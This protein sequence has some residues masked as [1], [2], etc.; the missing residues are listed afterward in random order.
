MNELNHIDIS[1]WDKVG[2]GGNG[3]VYTHPQEPGSIDAYATRM[4]QLAKMLIK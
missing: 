2:E 4:A 1:T 3:S